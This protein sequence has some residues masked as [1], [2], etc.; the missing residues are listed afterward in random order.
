MLATAVD[1]LHALLRVT[2]AAH[3]PKDKRRQVPA[4]WH[5]PRPYERREKKP[6]SWRS[7]ARQL[8]G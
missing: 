4:P 6:F 7:L 3:T 1:L 5:W 8:G 2:I